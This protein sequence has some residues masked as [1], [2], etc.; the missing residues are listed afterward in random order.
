MGNV[1]LYNDSY[2]FQQKIRAGGILIV[3][4]LAHFLILKRQ[5]IERE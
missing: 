1:G 5:E 3:G 2:K 4:T